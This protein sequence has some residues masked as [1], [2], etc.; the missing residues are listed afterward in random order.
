MSSAKKKSENICDRC[1]KKSECEYKTT[2]N[3]MVIIRC[4]DFTEKE[5]TK[6]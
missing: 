2:E 1:S 4:L 3:S 5:N 6:S